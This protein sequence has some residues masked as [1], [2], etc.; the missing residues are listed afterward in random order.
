MPK[1]YTPEQLIMGT[2][3]CRCG[4]KLACPA[5]LKQASTDVG[6]SAWSCSRRWLDPEAFARESV[7]RNAKGEVTASTDA[8][9]PAY[10]FDHFP[11]L[12]VVPKG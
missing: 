3:S 9:D 7:V 5:E 12:G 1:K 4:A 6:G 10:P 2:A 11:H 8:H